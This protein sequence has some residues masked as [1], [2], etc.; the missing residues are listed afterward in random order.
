MLGLPGC[1]ALTLQSQQAG[2]VVVDDGSN[3][4]AIGQVCYVVHHRERGLLFG[5][6]LVFSVPDLREGERER[7]RER[8]SKRNR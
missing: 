2:A 7:E 3:G 1:F 5:L 8:E 4:T 6:H